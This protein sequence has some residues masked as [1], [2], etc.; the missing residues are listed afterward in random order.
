VEELLFGSRVHGMVLCTDHALVRRMRTTVLAALGGE[1]AAGRGRTRVLISR[2]R[3]RCRRV[4]N[5]AGLLALA[6]RHGF[7]EHEFDGLDLRA[8]I[9]IM[10]DASAVLMP[11][12]A[13]LVH[14]LFTKRPSLVVELFA[15]NY[16]TQHTLGICRA[17]GHEYHQ[18]VAPT[19]QFPVS[20]PT[21]NDAVGMDLA[22][23]LP[24]IEAILESRLQAAA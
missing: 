7:E 1:P 12:G 17:L 8:Q 6:A 9:A 3:S 10:R 19:P 16:V 5:Y 11:H 24:L 14:T 4:T 22:A 13:A 18:V 21:R 23:N 20:L 2:Q 15:P